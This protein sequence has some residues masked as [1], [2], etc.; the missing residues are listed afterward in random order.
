MSNRLTIRL[1]SILAGQLLWCS[2]CDFQS[3]LDHIKS[4]VDGLRESMEKSANAIALAVP[5][6]RFMRLLFDFHS[7]EPKKV[8]EAKKLLKSI[9]PGFDPD[10]SYEVSVQVTADGEELPCF[11]VLCAPLP[12]RLIVEAYISNKGLKLL[13]ADGPAY[14]PLDGH[15]LNRKLDNILE[16]AVSYLTG[17]PKILKRRFDTLNGP[18]PIGAPNDVFQYNTWP[19]SIMA[20]L[21]HPISFP[22][23]NKL[24]M[25]LRKESQ[26]NLNNQLAQQRQF[27]ELLKEAILAARN[28]QEKTQPRGLKTEPWNPLH[29]RNFIIILIADSELERFKD[30]N[31]KFELWAHKA[32]E[33]TQFYQGQPRVPIL[34]VTFDDPDFRAV[35]AHSHGKIRWAAVDLVDTYILEKDVIKSMDEMQL[36]L[37][38]LRELSRKVEH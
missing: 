21:I 25:K 20:E 17:P 27:R 4:T 37:K 23:P 6:E 3:E 13:P 1:A 38:K 15:E 36:V 24:P 28:P 29:G 9:F 31:L 2:G 34:P 8:E 33:P 5:G 32:G 22:S 10:A 30:R 35:S 18:T 14:I 11:D 7:G 16:R 19:H 26:D 12:V